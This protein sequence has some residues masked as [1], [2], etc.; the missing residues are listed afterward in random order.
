ML[1]VNK[2]DRYHLAIETVKQVSATNEKV[3]VE[4]QKL[5]T[6]W[7]DALREHDKYILEYQK[8]PDYLSQIWEE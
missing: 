7:I 5:I 1:T 2:A 8:D 6:D 4:A 3:A